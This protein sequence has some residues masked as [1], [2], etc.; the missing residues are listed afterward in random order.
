[1]MLRDHGGYEENRCTLTFRTRLFHFGVVIPKLDRR[2]PNK[3]GAEICRRRP[4]KGNF[5]QILFIMG[6]GGEGDR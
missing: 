6:K 4:H 5:S 2:P 3:T 1:M